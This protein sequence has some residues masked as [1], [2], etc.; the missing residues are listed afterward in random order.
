VGD[1][2]PRYAPERPLPAYAYVPGGRTP[3]PRKDPRGHSHGQRERLPPPLDP[4]DFEASGEYRFAID[5]F[6]HGFYWE[7]HEV[8]EGLWLAAGK[9]GTVAELLKGLIKL[10][11]AGV[12]EQQGM[13]GGVQKHME[14]AR[15]HFARVFTERREVL[16]LNATLLDGLSA[17]RGDHERPRLVLVGRCS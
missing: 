5:L 10:C 11:A 1:P 14:A 2:P 9:T 8:L 6:N 17:W 4:D 16:G 7:A 12:K 3:H 15:A 13:S